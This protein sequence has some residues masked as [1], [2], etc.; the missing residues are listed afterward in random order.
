MIDIENELFTDVYNEVI[1][2]FPDIYM[3]GEYEIAQSSFPCLYFMEQDNSVRKST[4]TGA[5]V[6]NYADVLYEATAYSNKVPGKKAECKEILQIVD[7]VMSRRG[8]RRT[9]KQIVPNMLDAT[10]CRMVARYEGT[11]SENK[12]IYRR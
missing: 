4:M 6:E 2:E 11:V 1:K 7:K 3:T 9:M 8:L 12:I 5:K 10:V